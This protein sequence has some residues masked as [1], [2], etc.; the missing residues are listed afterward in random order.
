M[1]HAEKMPTPKPPKI[2]LPNDWPC[3]VKSAIVHIISLAHFSITYTRGWAAN[4]INARVR[5]ASENDRLHQEI[6]LLREELRIKDTRM[7]AVAAHRRPRGTVKLTDPDRD[8]PQNDRS[9][10]VPQQTH[11]TSL[12][13]EKARARRS[14]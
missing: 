8:S 10:A 12:Q 2:S 11:V 6:A 7:A 3:H 5:I 9:P 13:S 1:K 14:R 4:S